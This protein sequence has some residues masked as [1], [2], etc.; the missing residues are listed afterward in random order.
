V[1]DPSWDTL[2]ALEGPLADRQC[3]IAKNHALADF[4]VALPKC[5]PIDEPMDAS[6]AMELSS[7]EATLAGVV[8]LLPS[9]K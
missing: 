6:V 9:K 3:A 4:V 2:I 8:A 7:G 5:D 1:D